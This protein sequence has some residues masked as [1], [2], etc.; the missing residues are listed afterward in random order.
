[1][2]IESVKLSRQALRDASILFLFLMLAAF[3]FQFFLKNKVLPIFVDAFWGNFSMLLLCILVWIGLRSILLSNK[4][5]LLRSIAIPLLWIH[6]VAFYLQFVLYLSAGYYPDFVLLLTGEKSRFMAFEGAPVIGIGSFRPTGLLAEPSTYFYVALAL[7]TLIVIDQGFKSN[8]K[9]IV[10]TIISMFLSFS[11]AALII[12][13]IFVI[14]L[15]FS[16]S[17]KKQYYVVM[18]IA[19]IAIA[20][21]G[22]GASVS[23]LYL[24]QEKKFTQSSAIRASLINA[25]INRDE[26]AKFLAYG[27]FAVDRRISISSTGKKGQE[28]MASLNDVGMLVFFVIEFGYLGV[29]LF[30][31]LCYLIFKK[32]RN[33]LFLFLIF[34]LTKAN[35]FIPFFILYIAVLMGLPK[36]NSSVVSLQPEC[37]PV[38]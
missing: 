15:F 23:K 35:P 38:I 10:L 16:Q 21:L 17:I 5:N 26:S 19:I 4:G 2:M 24:S 31:G 32:S 30:L 27:P 25:I 20:I 3:R 6:V 22:V 8:K 11:T 13:S 1:M 12:A 34:S 18:V 33:K 36:K 28:T 29:I 7:A 14:Y 37:K 9:L